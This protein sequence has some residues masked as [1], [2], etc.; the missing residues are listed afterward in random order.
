MKKVIILGSGNGSNFEAIVKYFKNKQVEI[1]CVSNKKDAFILER[2]KKLN[3]NCF[4]VLHEELFSFLNSQTYD[5]IAL[6]G[7]MRLLPKEVVNLG[8]IIN[9]HPSLL[10]RYKGMDVIR[11]SYDSGESK[12]GV[13]VHV[14]DEGVDSGPIIAQ[15][16]VKIKRDLTFD[17]LEESIHAVEHK[18]YPRVIE[19]LLFNTSLDIN[20]LLE[21]SER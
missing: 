20:D 3:I 5:L 14:V 18:L 9:I 21:E 1:L 11:K 7:Y 6:A 2:A 19:H 17:K 16:P 4:Y 10:P 8:N 15:V 13:T 12:T